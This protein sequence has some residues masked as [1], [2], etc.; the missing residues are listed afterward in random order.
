MNSSNQSA[1][2]NKNAGNAV[3]MGLGRSGLACAS[4]L[5]DQ[6]WDV[7]LAEVKSQPHLEDK[8]RSTLPGV[9]IHAPLDP[10]MI[11]GKDLVVLSCT[12]APSNLGI[13]EIARS[14]GVRV[15][16]SLELFFDEAPQPIISVTG[17]NGKSSVTTLVSKIIERHR[18][19][20]QL[21]GCRG[22]PYM[23]LLSKPDT[24]VFLLELSAP[25]LEQVH[26]VSSDVA[27][28]LNVSPDHMQR[29]DDVSSLVTAMAKVIRDAKVAVINRDDPIAAALPT[30]GERITFGLNPP[31]NDTDYGV[32]DFSGTQW[33][34]RGETKLI[35]LSRCKLSGDHNWMN[36][37]AGCA[38]A[39]ASG[40]PTK[41]VRPVVTNFEGLPYRCR[42]EGEWNGVKWVNDARS[43]N[44]GAALAAIQSDSRPVILIAGG[45]S[46]GADFSLIPK[47]VNGRLRGCV[48]FGRDR[49]KISEPFNGGI[50]KHHVEDIY[51][52]ISVANSMTKAGDCVVFSPGCA[53]NDQFSDYE[54]RGKTFSQALQMQ[55]L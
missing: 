1:K 34:V 4:Y 18:A 19:N 10:D 55:V 50:A 20:V 30:D 2:T 46:K 39:D 54:H 15:M 14:Y 28:I 21:G 31:E 17:T 45:L 52:A 44:V 53:S 38:I 43:A 40:Y 23:E 42:T 5:I 8:I 3:I 26:Q 49:R 24:D 16:N 27:A 41:A 32:E 35:N 13:M 11:A 6:G 37:L 22:R 9:S 7:E 12:S 29:Y 33:L 25:H 51:D 36:M 48:F 47:Q